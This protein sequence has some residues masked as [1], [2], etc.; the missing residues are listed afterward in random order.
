MLREI[1]EADRLVTLGS[2]VE[3][4]S[5]VDVCDV[6][7]GTH[8]IDHKLY[9]LKVAVVGRKVKGRKFFVSV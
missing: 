2:Y 1:V 4:V 9:E 6:D 5:T 3:T 8:L 7:V